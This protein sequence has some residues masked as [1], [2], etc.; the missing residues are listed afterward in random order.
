[1]CG[2]RGP[3][4]ALLGT[5]TAGI[6]S[7][8]DLVEAGLHEAEYESRLWPSAPGE[9]RRDG[10]GRAPQRARAAPSSRV[11]LACAQRLAGDR[12]RG[13]DCLDHAFER[14]GR[15]VMQSTRSA[16]VTAAAYLEGGGR[17]ADA[18]SVV[19][20]AAAAAAETSCDDRISAITF[21]VLS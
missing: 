12:A 17:V 6:I 13:L 5:A 19:A 8:S 1:M 10:G 18:R 15:A 14:H 16:T 20:A 7:I 3:V 11:P 21:L 9:R 2:A 4:N